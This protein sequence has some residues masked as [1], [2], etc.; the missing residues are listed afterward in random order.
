MSSKRIMGKKPLAIAGG[1]RATDSHS[2]M[3]GFSAVR[4][5]LLGCVNNSLAY[6]AMAHLPVLPFRS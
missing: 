5:I 1:A 2:G 4:M 3:L 6:L